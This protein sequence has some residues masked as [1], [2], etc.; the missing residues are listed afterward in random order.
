MRPM[1]LL[2]MVFILPI[3]SCTLGTWIVGDSDA[4]PADRN[5]PTYNYSAYYRSFDNPW[6]GRSRDELVDALGP[7][8]FIYEARPRFTDYWEAGF[9]AYTYV[10]AGQDDSI[11]HCIDAFVVD[12]PTQTV[13]KYYCR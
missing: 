5:Y 10:Y 12:E 6:I 9:P 13:I 8:D 11:G 3:D 1:A 7:P 4:A 2:L